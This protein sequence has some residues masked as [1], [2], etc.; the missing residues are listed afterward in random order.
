MTSQEKL[1][2]CYQSLQA[3]LKILN[4]DFKPEIALILGTGLGKLADEIAIKATLNYSD[5]DGC[6]IST[7]DSHNGRFVFG[8]IQNVPVVIMQGRVHYYEGYAMQ[9]V[10]IP[11]RLMKLMGAKVLFITNSVGACNV[12]DFDAGDLMLITDHISSFV[13]SPLIG[14]NF[15]NFGVR[16]PDMGEVYNLQLRQIVAN[17]AKELNINLKQGVYLQVSGPQFETPS[18]VKMYRNRGADVLGMSS[19]CEAMV[20]HHAG[21]K[22]VGVSFISNVEKKGMDATLEE[23]IEAADKNYAKFQKLIAT[24]ITNIYKQKSL[25]E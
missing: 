12:D 2:K 5:I 1:Q 25:F 9:D 18:E 7:V 24:S 14:A 16:F 19:V 23:I 22:I 10:V 13:P 8:Y 20:A 21:M 3:K 6:P 4:I 17:T 15:D 11:T